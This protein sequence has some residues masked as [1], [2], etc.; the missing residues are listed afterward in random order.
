LSTE[1]G[2]RY[3]V[4]AF[5][6]FAENSFRERTPSSRASRAAAGAKF[7][8]SNATTASARPLMTTSAG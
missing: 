8:A 5:G 1:E 7:F 2:D 4:A 6:R 3:Y